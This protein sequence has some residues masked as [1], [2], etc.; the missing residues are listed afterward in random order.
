M[1]QRY[2]VYIYFC[3][4]MFLGSRKPRGELGQTAWGAASGEPRLR[5]PRVAACLGRVLGR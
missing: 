4:I 1:F 3:V 2:G 5:V